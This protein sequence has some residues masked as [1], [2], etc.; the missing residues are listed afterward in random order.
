[1]AGVVDVASPLAGWPDGLG[2]PGG[3][4][5]AP[6]GV[7][8]GP[9]AALVDVSAGVLSRRLGAAESVSTPCCHGLVR[10]SV[11][12]DAAAS[13]TVRVCITVCIEN[14]TVGSVQGTSVTRTENTLWS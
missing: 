3:A 2:G 9:V 7:Q 8:P 1:M 14:H 6:A 12:S 13:A 11:I 4:D 5:E 10:T